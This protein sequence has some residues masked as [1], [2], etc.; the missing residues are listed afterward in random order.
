MQQPTKLTYA[1]PTDRLLKALI[2]SIEH[3]TGRRK[4]EKVYARI[5]EDVNTQTTFWQAAL[6]ALQV[7]L[8]TIRP[9]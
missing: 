8:L 3:L 7:N 4:L 5:L 1:S 9:V 2:Y 6:N